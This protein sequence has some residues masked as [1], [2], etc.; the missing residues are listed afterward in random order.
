MTWQKMWSPT[1]VSTSGHNSTLDL[2]GPSLAASFP[3][4]DRTLCGGFVLSLMSMHPRRDGRSNS[5]G[6]RREHNEALCIIAPTKPNFH[7]CQLPG[8]LLLWGTFGA[9]E[10]ESQAQEGG[11]GG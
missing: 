5:G 2:T 8:G 1:G 3:T 7:A 9:S 6:G 4:S 10:V 11:V